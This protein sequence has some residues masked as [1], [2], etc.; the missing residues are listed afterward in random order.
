MVPGASAGRGWGMRALRA[1]LALVLAPHLALAGPPSCPARYDDGL[2]YGERR[3]M[4]P[5]EARPL[6]RREGAILSLVG[7]RGVIE[8]EDDPS[9]SWPEWPD[10][11]ARSAACVDHHLVDAFDDP[12]GILVR[13]DHYEDQDF[14]WIDRSTGVILRLGDLQRF[15]P[16][17]RWLVTVGAAECCGISFFGIEVWRMGDRPEHVWLWTPS[18]HG[19]EPYRFYRFLQ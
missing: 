12:R 10:T 3:A 8:L 7:D 1:V 11:D 14:L 6:V 9:C 19:V 17:G 16:D 18:P 4:A 2:G 13:R 5:S 15:S